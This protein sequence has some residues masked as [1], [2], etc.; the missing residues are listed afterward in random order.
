VVDEKLVQVCNRADPS[1]A[2]QSGRWAR[3]NPRDEPPE[4]C[5]LCQPRPAPLGEPLE[6]ARKNETGASDGIALTQHDVGGEVSGGPAVEERGCVSSEFVEEIAQG[7]ALLCVKRKILHI[8]YGANV[9]RLMLQFDRGFSRGS[10]IMLRSAYPRPSR[11]PPA[12]S[13]A[14]TCRLL[15]VAISE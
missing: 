6:Q 1:D 14:S 11:P 3:S 10:P 2:K 8:P 9:I 5:V 13:I 7:K 15:N 4:L 12:P